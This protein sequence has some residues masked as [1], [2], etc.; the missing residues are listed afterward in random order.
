MK[1]SFAPLS[2]L[3]F[4]CFFKHISSNYSPLSLNLQLINQTIQILY[5]PRVEVSKPCVTSVDSQRSSFPLL[6][7]AG[8]SSV[9][10]PPLLDDAV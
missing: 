10:R 8:E 6:W 1:M 2:F 9:F 7:L 4:G 5:S 3:S